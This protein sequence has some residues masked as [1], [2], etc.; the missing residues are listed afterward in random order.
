M[1]LAEGGGKSARLSLEGGRGKGGRVATSGP[2]LEGSRQR[3]V[4]LHPDHTSSS[5]TLTDLETEPGRFSAQPRLQGGQAV[6]PNWYP[7]LLTVIC[8]LIWP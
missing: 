3:P 8:Q 7:N 5:S 1:L 6:G 2:Y 4:S